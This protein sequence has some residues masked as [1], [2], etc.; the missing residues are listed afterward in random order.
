MTPRKSW[1]S[2]R[3]FQQSRKNGFKLLEDHLTEFLASN[4]SHPP[5]MVASRTW[6]C[7]PREK[8]LTIPSFI[9]LIKKKKTK[10]LARNLAKWRSSTRQSLSL[11]RRLRLNNLRSWRKKKKRTTSSIVI[12]RMK[13]M[14]RNLVHKM[15]CSNSRLTPKINLSDSTK[16][17]SR[18]FQ[19]WT[20]YK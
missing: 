18:S 3:P 20:N 11:K 14:L 12:W 6:E 4:L 9:T 17:L 13:M 19:Y 5:L 16:H 2:K 10:L 8:F 1:R 7:L 15:R